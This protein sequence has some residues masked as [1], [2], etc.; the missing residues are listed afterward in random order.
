QGLPKSERHGAQ[1]R[2][3]GAYPRGLPFRQGGM[4]GFF[5]LRCANRADPYPEQGL[6]E[7]CPGCG[8]L[9]HARATW[10]PADSAA[11]LRRGASAAGV[12]PDELTDR[13]VGA[14]P[15]GHGAAWL[16]HEGAQGG[17]SFKERGAEVLAAALRRRSIGE[18]FLDSSGNAGLAVARACST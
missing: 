1:S 14:A 2:I 18:C 6:P 12:A 5:A 16:V 10:A 17:G 7:V 9:W 11:G 15:C 4:S 3:S 8:S 13:S